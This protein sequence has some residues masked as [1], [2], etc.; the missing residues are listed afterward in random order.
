MDC[1]QDSKV[2]QHV[3]AHTRGSNWKRR[4]KTQGYIK[5]IK[6]F[7]FII[8]FLNYIFLGSDGAADEN[9]GMYFL[10]HL[11]KC[12]ETKTI[13]FNFVFVLENAET[14]NIDNA[15]L[16]EQKPDEGEEQDNE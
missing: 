16:D 10:L 9:A 6:C 5:N 1:T 8:E 3:W 7:F 4:W 11:K 14:S 2:V 13:I 15:E 12:E